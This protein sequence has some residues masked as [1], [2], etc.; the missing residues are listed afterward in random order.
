M[1]LK[2]LVSIIAAISVIAASST[3]FAATWRH[4]RKGEVKL[5]SR[6]GENDMIT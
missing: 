4:S 5:P 2:K 3:G 1:K 6:A